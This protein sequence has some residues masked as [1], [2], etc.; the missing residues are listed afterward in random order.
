M[1]ALPL[2]LVEAMGVV[3]FAVALAG[4]AGLLGPGEGL[5]ALLVAGWL[6][7]AAL[8]FALLTCSAWNFQV[9]G[10][11]ELYMGQGGGLSK[12]ACLQCTW[13]TGLEAYV[14]LP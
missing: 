7:L 14:P 1:L 11:E 12:T 6:T 8:A 9:P 4:G 5:R 2:R 10:M 3:E 13:S